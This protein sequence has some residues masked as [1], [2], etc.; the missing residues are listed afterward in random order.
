MTCDQLSGEYEMYALGMTGGEERLE[1]AEHLDR[2]CA[3]CTAGVREARGLLALI[4]T[5]VPMVVPP[6]RLR[7]RI[8]ASV[9][10]ERRVWGWTPLW[11][12]TTAFFLVTAFYFYGRDRD[13]A[14]QLARSRAESRA[15]A[16][17]LARLNDV[18]AMLEQPETKQVIFGTGAPAPPQGRVF[19]NPRS[20]ILLLA[21]NLPAPPAGKI[22]AMW[23][24]PKSGDPVP[25]GLFQSDNTGTAFHLRRGA[26]DMA[27]VKAVAVTLEPAGGVS[28][29]TTQP[30]I[31][32]VL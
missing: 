18:L 20:G 21:S 26:L 19:V 11:V 10:V 1:L 4:G 15:Q 7:R 13:N 17:E 5:T 8:M 29:P 28:K 25:A 14:L 23:V 16:I 30:V 3:T 22:Y 32:A 2:G 24:I 12:A 9:G 27:A 6:P 31:V